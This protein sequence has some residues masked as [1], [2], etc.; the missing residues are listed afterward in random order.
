MAN[1]ERERKQSFD[2]GTKLTLVQGTDK[3][4]EIQKGFMR[5]F[6]KIQ[7]DNQI[8]HKKLEKYFEDMTEHKEELDFMNWVLLQNYSEHLNQKT[9][10]F[11][12]SPH[13]YLTF[14][15]TAE[16]NSTDSQEKKE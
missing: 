15:Q 16:N 12:H 5:V 8:I 11:S 7:M 14:V 3:K 10:G 2:G 6:N 13:E 1:I 4:E 9:L